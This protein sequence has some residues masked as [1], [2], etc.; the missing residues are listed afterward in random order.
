MAGGVHILLNRVLSGRGDFA[1]ILSAAVD[2][3]AASAGDFPQI[4]QSRSNA[5]DRLFCR[6]G[7]F[8]VSAIPF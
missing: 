2:F 3:Y 7:A 4:T 6:N 8:V 5:G 1:H